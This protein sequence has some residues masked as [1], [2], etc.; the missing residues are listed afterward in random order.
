MES[1]PMHLARAGTALAVGA[2]LTLG[3]AFTP[4]APAHAETTN[5]ITVDGMDL[6]DG[7]N[8][9]INDLQTEQVAPGLLHV[10]YE[11]LDSGGWQ[12]INILKAKLSEKTVK[13]KYLS[14]ETVS[15]QGTTVTDLVDRNGAIAGVNLDRF[16]INNSYAASG[17]GVS[18]GK[19][20]KSGNDDAHASIGVDSAG[21]GTLVDL[22]LEGTVTL[23]DSNTVA[24]SGIN[25]EGVWAPGVVL[26]NSHWG[27]FTRDRLF[28]QSAAG[29]IEVWLD[30]DGVVTKAA[31][32]TAGDD[33]PI[34]DGAQVLATFA[35]R[36]EATALSSLKVG[37]TVQIA[38]GI[39][40][41]VDVTEA[42]GA[43]H[44]LVRDGAASP[45]ANEA[46][47]TGLNP[48]TMIGFGKDRATAYF[49]VVDG[50]QGNAK[51][52]AF[53]QQQDL[54]LDLG[55]WDA[56]NADGGGS[57]QMNTRHAGDTTTTVENS[58]SDGYE[59][60]DGD[61]M[62]FTLAQPS[63]GELLSF[64]VEP[65]M[66]D[67]DAL[68]VFPG[69][70]RSLS[71]SGY[72]E[73]GS[74]VA[75]TPSVWSTSDAQVAAVKDGQVAGKADGKATITARDG[76]AT[77]KAKVEVLGTLARLEVDQNVVNLE[78]QG[79]SQVVTFEGYDDQGFRAPVELS[80]L[81]ITNSNPDVI[82]VKPTSDG[83]AEITAVGAQGT[84]MLGFGHGDHTVQ[85]SVAVPLEINTIDDFSDISGWSAANDRAPGCNIQTGSGHDGAASIQL[86]YNFTQSTATRGCYGVAPGAVQGTY[87]GIDI[88]GRPQKLSVWI[89]GD[90]KGALLRMQVMQSNGVT[91]WI[92]GPGGSQSLHVTWTDWKRVDFMV[93]STF[94][95]PLKFQRIR[96]LETVA[97]K[98]Y[99]GSLEFSQIFAYLPPEGTASPAVE[100]FDDPVLSATGSTD[101]APLRVAVMSDAQFVAASP[102]S[103]AVAGARDALREIVAAKPDVLIID[104]DFVDEASPADFALAKSIL[105]EELADATFPWY[106]LPGNHE[107][108]GGPISNFESVFGP[109]WREFDLKH[110][111]VIGLN[112]SSGKLQ[113][114]FDQVKMLRAQLD[115][116][117]DDPSITGV[118]VFTHMPIDDPLPTKGSQLTDRTEA[119]MITDWVS[120]F[121]ADSGKS[122]AMVNGHVGV[123]HTSSLDGVPMVIN[124]NSGKA[125]ASTV[126]DG[127][128]TGWSMLGV[129]PAQGKWASADGRWLTDE[130]KTRVD[131]LTVQSPA[132][133]LTPGEQVELKPTVLQD[134]TR[135]VPVEWPVSHTW[136]GS[137]AVFIGA[138]D[139]AP[140][141]AAAAIDPQTGVLTAL[142][143]G[144]GS[145]TL[146]VNDATTSVAVNVG[147]ST[148]QVSGTA[149]TGQT[150]TASLGSW[151][152]ALKVGYQWRLDGHPI[153]GA[154]AATYTVDADAVGHQLD[155]AV[156][157]AGD[158][159]ATVTLL[160]A[161]QSPLVQAPAQEIPSVGID[162]QAVVGST[163]TATGDW[164]QGTVLT[165]QWLRD[166][167]AIA[168]AISS[169]YN[170]ASADK[171]H[172]L[173]VQVSAV[174]DGFT[175]ATV[176]SPVTASVLGA[177]ST[178]P[179][180]PVPAVVKAGR[181]SVTGPVRVGA[182][183]RAATSGWQAGTSLMYQWFRSGVPIPGATARSYPI[184][185]ADAG[186]K[187][188]V[189]VIGAASGKVSVS[190]TSAS[191]RV[192]QG[193]LAAKR[194]KIKGWVLAGHTVRATLG[195]HTP[196]AAISYR[197]LVRGKVVSTARTLRI[198]TSA[199]RSRITLR[200]K[201]TKPGY[202]S[203][204]RSARSLQ[205]R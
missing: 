37:D 168:A 171:G 139:K 162:G 68:R 103:G 174:R 56:I 16:D 53:A 109:T 95:F 29:G 156:T 141:T 49:V 132:A 35:D 122:I 173:S 75:G 148:V 154:T 67:D 78:K 183:V 188:S 167:E 130:V 9:V 158:G 127:G 152:D 175:D 145:A 135:E 64:A 14:P 191:A 61:G 46:Y 164:A 28:G 32:P 176:T 59:R 181:V 76:V 45:Y 83:R 179:T 18:D 108:M 106:Y 50:R 62:G 192:A 105:E 2:A 125:P 116:A 90:G 114:Y 197:W 86:N 43:W 82:D 80:D 99:T 129:D 204:T 102:D 119:E 199:K 203:L 126:A 131:S 48:R 39:K 134:G 7:G 57:S 182:R 201:Y 65:A 104:G 169:R 110:T 71:A 40:D 142:R 26:Y 15:G 93:P 198:P 149:V 146:M 74:A 41:S 185:A 5:T 200:V 72:D 19:I 151:A 63:S 143:Q 89:K 150:L 38:Y 190:V 184:V 34:P 84:A 120:E 69:M 91:N 170:V 195:R 98:Q 52:M 24:I 186:K 88:P 193:V 70:H 157:V 66:A 117:A 147:D 178:E 121:R 36:A 96:A 140:N 111:K 205:V 159:R 172:R 194:V 85:I 10:S 17:W 11:R 177:S 73:A 123:F 4:V 13:L 155:V 124:G 1:R 3:L 27:S 112:S 165:Y 187:L 138:V 92:D 23:P 133:T 55:V 100:T 189:R 6:N 20:L 196:G 118:L 58:P 60:S 97:A 153:S 77:G 25:A 136:T 12:Q 42:G 166:G 144:Q 94:V 54:L 137:D 160:G 51:G 47:Y 202:R 115:E 128:F 81:D 79:A 163:L 33:G 44:D 87:S 180:Q 22:A 31:Q 21:L 101:S 30:A 161:P 113:T 8:A 107:V